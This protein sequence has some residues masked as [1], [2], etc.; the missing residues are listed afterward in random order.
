MIGWGENIAGEATGVV[1]SY[2][3]KNGDEI[4]PNDT[5]STGVVTI[6]SS[7]LRNIIAVSASEWFGLALKTDG[8]VIGWGCNPKGCAIGR[9]TPD[10]YLTN[11]FVII[12]SHILSNIVSI[13]AGGIFSLGLKQD[14]TVVAWGEQQS[15][16]A[17][18]P[19]PVNNDEIN[20]KARAAGINP[21]I[22][23]LP[24]FAPATGLP[25]TTN[26]G[27]MPRHSEPV[28]GDEI[29]DGISIGIKHDGTVMTWTQSHEPTPLTNVVAIA[30]H[31]FASL[32]LKSDGTVVGWSVMPWIPMRSQMYSV[33]GLSNVIA[34]T[35][36]GGLR[37]GGGLVRCIALK[38][39]GTV[40]T[41]GSQTTYG[42]A[43]PP[44]GLSNVVAV[45]A[46]YD[47]SIA[48]KKDGTVVGWGFDE[49]GQATG[50]STRNDSYVTNGLVTIDGQVLS[51]VKAIA[52]VEN[53]NL[54][55]K[56]DGTVVGWG[57]TCPKIPA[58]LSNVVAI[59]TGSDFCLAITTNS[60]VADKF[61]QK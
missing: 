30:A 29:R 41:W 16:E 12:D 43:T 56:T 33:A 25:N 27:S 14:G 15:V 46:G 35:V 36:G 8:T 5:S 23:L 7:V 21:V 49:D 59:A 19:I 4:I 47:H 18:L 34:I 11:G 48:L 24:G 10:Q 54:A 55:L 50:I 22:G 52:A 44:A 57:R 61:R 53:Y 9:E 6:A 17:V 38:K 58:G 13:A 2:P 20:E 37:N 31:Q 39:D 1:L 51:N 32:A 28:E 3:I 60:A 45:A 42:D 26:I 40:F